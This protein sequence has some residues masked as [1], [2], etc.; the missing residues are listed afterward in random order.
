MIEVEKKFQPT[1]EQLKAMLEGAEFLGEV[2][3]H[4]VYYDYPDYRLYKKDIMLRNRNGK[5]E[6]KIR[7]A[8]ST[9][10]ETEEKTEIEKYFNTENLEKFIQEN[11]EIIMEYITKRLKYKKGGFTIDVD[12]TD[13][14][15]GKR[16]E[17]CEIE[18]MVDSI[19]EVDN[20][21]EAV[22]RFAESYNF[23]NKK[24]FGKHKE[25]LRVM[26]PEVFTELFGKAQ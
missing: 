26:K 2:V 19:D 24:M 14:G 21:R 10:E 6:L 1:E 13:F 17:M 3:N 9:H 23:E 4:D 25:Y 22:L 20:A 5:Y 11:F 7:T 18:L 15:G 16:Y 12:K 8:S